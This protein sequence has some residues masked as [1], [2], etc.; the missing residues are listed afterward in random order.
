MSELASILLKE[1]TS[2]IKKSQN[3]N[4]LSITAFGDEST[5][6]Q[7]YYQPTISP[8]MIQKAQFR[9]YGHAS[10]VE[11]FKK[12]NLPIYY[13]LRFGEACT[14]LDRALHLVQE[15]GLHTTITSYRVVTDAAANQNHH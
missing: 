12:W 2:T 8:Q 11:F 15:K 7:L 1:P 10:T 6:E 3:D 5:L 4:T 9:L 13:Q 14:R